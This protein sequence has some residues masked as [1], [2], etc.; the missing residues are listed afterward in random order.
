MEG[1]SYDVLHPLTVCAYRKREKVTETDAEEV[2]KSFEVFCRKYVSVL[3]K[4]VVDRIRDILATAEDL[5]ETA[6]RKGTLVRYAGFRNVLEQVL[7]RFRE[8]FPDYP[9]ETRVVLPPV[10]EVIGIPR[11]FS[12]VDGDVFR[13]RFNQHHLDKF[14]STRDLYPDKW[15]WSLA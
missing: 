5:M 9:E 8:A 1:F 10:V 3:T 13:E 4:A 14:R 6:A 2:I 15:H 12:V 11:A 7:P